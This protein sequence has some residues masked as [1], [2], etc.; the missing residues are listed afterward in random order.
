LPSAEGNN[1]L[2]DN[3]L[4]CSDEHIEDVLDMLQWQK[5]GRVM[6]TGGLEAARLKPWHVEAITALHP[7]QIFF[8]Y[9]TPDNYEPL[10]QAARL[11]QAAGIRPQS[12]VLRSYVLLGWPGDTMDK[13]ESRLKS[14]LALGVMPMAMLWR[15][16]SGRRD[17][18]WVKFTWPWARP[19]AMKI[20]DTALAAG[21]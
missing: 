9:D 21:L 8:A 10:A 14:V 18:A 5:F 1:V 11:F 17:P 19:A 15:D 6:F 7:K 3:L 2:D 16:D 4:A 20:P 13:A 12:H